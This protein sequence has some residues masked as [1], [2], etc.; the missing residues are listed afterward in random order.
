MNISFIY[1]LNFHILYYRLFENLSKN[2]K[3]IP[4]KVKTKVQ[5]EVKEFVLYKLIWGSTEKI[6]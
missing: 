6:S 1:W 5:A 2:V 4:L 3:N